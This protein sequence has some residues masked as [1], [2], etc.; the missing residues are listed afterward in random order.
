[1]SDRLQVGSA[2]LDS[3]RTS[4]A[5]HLVTYMRDVDSVSILATVGRSEFQVIDAAGAAERIESRD[6]LVLAVSLVLDSVT[7]KPEPGDRV[8]EVD[9]A[10]TRTYEVM[11]PG[12]E[13]CWRWSDPFNRTLR[14]HTKLV[15]TA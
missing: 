7:V 4:A 5:S 3:R 12:S 6:Y 1:V 11:R 2:W 10:T 13:P 8:V 15:E 14:I 9:G